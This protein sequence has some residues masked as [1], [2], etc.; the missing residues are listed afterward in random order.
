M[1]RSVHT[2]LL[3]RAAAKARTQ[4]GVIAWE[5]LC[6]LGISSATVS[7]WVTAGVLHRVLPGVYA[8][9]HPMLTVH[10]EWM[11]AQLWAG[12]LTHDTSLMIHGLEPRRGARVHVTVPPSSSARSRVL[13]V[14]R[15]LVPSEQI[16]TVGPFNTTN[17]ARAIVDV[18][19]TSWPS[20]IRA[21]LDAAIANGL[22]DQAVMDAVMAG[23]RGRRGRKRMLAALAVLEDTT[24]M[25]RSRTE[26]RI[27]DQ[28]VARGIPAPLVNFAVRR[29]GA[30][31][32]EIDLYW[33]HARLAV[34][35]DGP[36]HEL[37]FQR[38]RDEE[39]DAWLWGNLA[40]TTLRYPVRTVRAED[41]VDEI[42]PILAAA[43]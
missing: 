20:R 28:L 26:R 41:V 4:F 39:R 27:R 35:L 6:S 29:N 2:G 32:I 18:A 33:A 19:D 34:E 22:Y 24:Q 25:Y 38:A 42:T 14:H 8:V 11:A 36:Q 43:A 12:L 37:P 21:L 9:G 5:Q 17:W 3:A 40:V 31:D 15:S 7:R 1:D 30:P 23:S 10:G 16:I 13:R